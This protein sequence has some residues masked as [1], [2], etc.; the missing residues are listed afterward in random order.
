MKRLILLTFLCGALTLE[1]RPKPPPPPPSNV[2]W[3]K[4]NNFSQ[5]ASSA[6]TP[7]VLT[8]S[9]IRVFAN[10]NGANASQDG[11]WFRR[12]G[13]WASLG[14]PIVALSPTQIYDIP[15]AYIR[16]TGVARG[17]VTGTYYAALHIGRGYPSPIYFPLAWATSPDG[18]TWTYRGRVSMDG[19]QSENIG[20]Y[21]DPAN[22]I[23]DEAKSATLVDHLNST[24]N[25]FLSWGNNGMGVQLGL[26]YS[27]N[28]T[29]WF[30]HRQNGVPVNMWPI[31][32]EQPTFVA[33]IQ[34]TFG[35]YHLLARV[36]WP[37]GPIRHLYSCDGLQWRVLD[38]VSPVANPVSTKG[39]NLA[40]DAPTNTL[41][42]LTS[43]Q[44]WS[45]TDNGFQC[46]TGGGGS[47]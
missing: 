36:N 30:R 6:Y 22:L 4:L 17:T 31:A 28:G 7:V 1:A 9:G 38:M 21:A 14:S 37:S 20:D 8:P 35:R 34:S 44:H 29:A 45:F 41:H 11:W 23:V 43:G 25:R 2:P 16:T 3:V 42:A 5:L 10:W 47:W 32:G 33:A 40:Y 13:T 46:P 18:L 19:V 26:L 15:N 12:E 27:A 39:T 24:N